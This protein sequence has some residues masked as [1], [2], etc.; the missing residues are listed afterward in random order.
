MTFFYYNI[1]KDYV[2]LSFLDVGQGDCCLIETKN[3]KR[4]LIDGG[5]T[6]NNNFEVGDNIVLPYLLDKGILK[7][8]LII[9]S[10]PHDD[11]IEGLIS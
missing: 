8:D 5:G 2:E 10:H 1:P 7:L 9:L 6:E 4:I 11:H 3:N